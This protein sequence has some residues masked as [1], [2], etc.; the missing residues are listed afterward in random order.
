[1]KHNTITVNPFVIIYCVNFIYKFMIFIN[2][3]I[4]IFRELWDKGKQISSNVKAQIP[5]AANSD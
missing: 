1:M 3:G 5:A 4:L 2:M